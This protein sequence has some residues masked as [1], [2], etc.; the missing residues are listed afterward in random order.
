[1]TLLKHT[2]KGKDYE[3]RKEPFM[4][5]VSDISH[6]IY[7]D[8]YIFTCRHY[9]K[10]RI[11]STPAATA[12]PL[13]RGPVNGVLNNTDSRTPPQ[14]KHWAGGPATFRGILWTGI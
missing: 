14:P 2:E 10:I 13:L 1:M 9:H 8:W 5:M 3:R 7:M 6:S 4:A 11:A 12:A